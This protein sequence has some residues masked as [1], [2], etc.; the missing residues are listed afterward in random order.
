M[1]TACH[2]I[3]H[4][5]RRQKPTHGGRLLIVVSLIQ[6][7]RRRYQ[8][9]SANTLTSTRLKTIAQ[10][11]HAWNAP[12][13]PRFESSAKGPRAS[14]PALAT[15]KKREPS[16]RDFSARPSLRSPAA[17]FVACQNRSGGNPAGSRRAS[18]RRNGRSS[19]AKQPPLLARG[20]GL[21]KNTGTKAS[22]SSSCLQS[23]GK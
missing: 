18:R 16:A 11:R 15:D 22:S 12:F 19:R 14:G 2:P 10:A 13:L 8:R 1:V 6:E 5:C 23:V 21:E 17:L 7:S 9:K 3:P 4:K 20:R